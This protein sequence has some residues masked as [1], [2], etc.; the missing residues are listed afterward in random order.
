MTSQNH[1]TGESETVVTTGGPYVAVEV[2][3]EAIQLLARWYSL[4]MPPFS[5]PVD[6]LKQDVEKYLKDHGHIP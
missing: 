4:F 5:C 1:P 6:G 3:Q 2:H